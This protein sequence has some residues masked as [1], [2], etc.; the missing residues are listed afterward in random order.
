[1]AALVA[2]V[3]HREHRLGRERVLNAHAILVAYRQ[4][5]IGHSQTCDTCRVNRLSRSG[6][7]RDGDTWIVQGNAVESDVQTERNVRTG[8]IHVVALDAL[9]HD[10]KSTADNRLAAAG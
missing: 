10:A 2:D 5:V 1:M 7:S 8:V 9:V 4:F 6:T 3:I